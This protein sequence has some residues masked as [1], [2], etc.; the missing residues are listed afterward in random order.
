MVSNSQDNFS[1]L[2]SISSTAQSQGN[3]VP[4]PTHNINVPGNKHR[5]V[6][7]SSRTVVST[8]NNQASRSRI[9]PQ[10][11]FFVHCYL[12]PLKTAPCHCHLTHPLPTPPCP[13]WRSADNLAHG[14]NNQQWRHQTWQRGKKH[15]TDS[16]AR[17]CKTLQM[18]QNSANA[19]RRS[20]SCSQ[21]VAAALSTPL[22]EVKA[23]IT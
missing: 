5:P 8:K 16:P 11:F 10:T 7:A 6:C 14:G 17:G 13:D 1:V 18:L 21:N 22:V 19:E 3:S 2:S 20:L 4:F 12:H 23:L 15:L 9:A